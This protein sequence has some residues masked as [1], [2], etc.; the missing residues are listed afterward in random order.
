MYYAENVLFLNCLSLSAGL[1]V[2]NGYDL[3]LDRCSL[4]DIMN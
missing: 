2:F 1:C 4:L 3:T